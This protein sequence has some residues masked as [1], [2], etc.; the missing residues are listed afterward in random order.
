[1]LRA[2]NTRESR[3]VVEK[4]FLV[5]EEA[6]D[7]ILTRK[8]LGGHSDHSASAGYVHGFSVERLKDGIEKLRFDE[9]VI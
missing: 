9:F 6:L 4:I 2:S 3:A 7:V 8:A 1:M 5:I